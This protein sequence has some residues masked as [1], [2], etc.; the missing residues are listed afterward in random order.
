MLSYSISHSINSLA[1]DKLISI[2]HLQRKIAISDKYLD[3]IRFTTYCLSLL[4]VI[5]LQLLLGIIV[6]IIR[7]GDV[8]PNPGPTSSFDRGSSSSSSSSHATLDISNH[9]SFVH[10]NVQSIALKL[11]VLFAELC[12]FD[13]LAFSETWLNPSVIPSD[14]LFDSFQPPERKD[15]TGDSHG[16][17]ILYIK[18]NIHYK[19]R[20][21]LEIIGIECIWIE[22]VLLTKH[23][24][25][26]VYYRPPNTNAL[27]HSRIVDSI[28]LA[29][30]TGISDIIIT[31][32][33]NINMSNSEQSRKI[34]SLCQLFSFTQ[35]ITENTHFTENS[36]S[37]ID[38]VLTSNDNLISS[39][40][41]L[42]P[43]LQQ[44]IRY[45]CPIYGIL[46]LKKRKHKSLNEIY[47]FS[48]KVII[49]SSETKPLILIGT[50]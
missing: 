39:S 20:S 1:N 44:N 5:T 28:H 48:T 43:F 31:G 14:L 47:G 36:S 38:I 9:I 4:F 40:G 33:F 11:E 30:D 3:T 34:N 6:L 49:P 26:G 19:R 7:S 41:V 16:G 21:D 23:I 17:V 35:C 45:H 13:I 24:L 37:T 15:R 18:D 42:D 22:L 10:Y 32:D 12:D 50:H 46:N 25:F 29:V 2:P 8:H 27:Q